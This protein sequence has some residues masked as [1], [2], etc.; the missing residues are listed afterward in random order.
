M[1]GIVGKKFEQR[2]ACLRLIGE[3]DI[4]RIDHHDRDSWSFTTSVELVGENA[5]A[6][7]VIEHNASIRR[8]HKCQFLAVAIF[9]DGEVGLRQ[10]E[11]MIF[12]LS[13]DNRYQDEFRTSVKRGS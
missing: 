12:S 5:F 4:R 10:V 2:V 9:E 3:R 13:H 1:S 8:L 11:D 6:A 7:R